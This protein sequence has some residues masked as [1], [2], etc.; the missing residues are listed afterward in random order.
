MK[1]VEHYDGE[2]R[3]RKSLREDVKYLSENLRDEDLEELRLMGTTCIESS[4]SHGFE[5]PESICYTMEFKDKIVAMFGCVPVVDQEEFKVATLW[6]LSTNGVKLFPKRFVRLARRYVK[7][8]MGEYDTLMNYIHSSN[9]LS[10]KLV[11]GLRAELREGF[12]SPATNE[13]FIL[14]LI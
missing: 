12:H 5:A 10:M 8:F 6:M 13:P 11:K 1:Y 14:F 2:V 9:T 4:I 7:M 3:I